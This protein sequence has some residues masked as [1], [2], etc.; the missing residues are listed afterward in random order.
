MSFTSCF[1]AFVKSGTGTFA[2]VESWAS[3]PQI[4]LRTIAA[5]VTSFVMGPI[6][7]REEA[8]AMQP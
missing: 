7:S 5:S 8:K 6:W 3:T 1:K 2:L 4:V